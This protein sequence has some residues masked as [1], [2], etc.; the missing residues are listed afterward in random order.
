M[1]KFLFPEHYIGDLLV[2]NCTMIS[3]LEVFCL[4]QSTFYLFELLL[5]CFGEHIYVLGSIFNSVRI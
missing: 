3:R 5:T 2:Q 1:S 4:G